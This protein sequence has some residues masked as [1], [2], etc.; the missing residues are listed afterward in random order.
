MSM[1][2]SISISMSMPMSMSMSMPMPI[3]MP[4]S[5]CLCLPEH[6]RVPVERLS[7]PYPPVIDTSGTGIAS[8]ARKSEIQSHFLP[9][10]YF[11]CNSFVEAPPCCKKCA[12]SERVK[13][14]NGWLSL[15]WRIKSANGWLFTFADK[16]R[17]RLIVFTLA[18]FPSTL[19]QIHVLSIRTTPCLITFLYKKQWK[20]C[21]SI[22]KNDKNAVHHEI[23]RYEISWDTLFMLTIYGM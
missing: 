14:A 15:R 5:M 18:D 7:R 8:P 6:W 4:M 17:Q 19:Y 1:P 9:Q 11:Y 3:P 21:F 20:W 23:R 22:R 12:I 10:N 13:S 16:I 2:M